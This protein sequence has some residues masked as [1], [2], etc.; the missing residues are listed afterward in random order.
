MWLAIDIDGVLGDHV[1]HLINHLKQKGVLDCNF[2]KIDVDTWDSMI[3]GYGFK[4][5]FEMHL[6]DRDFIMGI[7]VIEGAVEAI[8]ELRR[9]HKIVIVTAR[10]EFA[11][12]ATVEWL[13]LN[14]FSYDDLLIGVGSER[15]DLDVDVLVDDNPNTIVE[16]VARD[17]VGIIFSQPWNMSLDPTDAGGK[18]LRFDNWRDIKNYILGLGGVGHI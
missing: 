5:I 12:D 6:F 7:P 17:R 2:S 8:S 13:G 1:L 15:V 14:G 16:F 18:F 4:E 3:G 10:P 9:Y 11:R